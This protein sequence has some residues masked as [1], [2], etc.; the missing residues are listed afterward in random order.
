MSLE[1][2]N[3]KDEIINYYS[4]KNFKEIMNKKYI[5]DNYDFKNLL[6]FMF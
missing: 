1:L 5:F 6:C 4:K 2:K 3:F